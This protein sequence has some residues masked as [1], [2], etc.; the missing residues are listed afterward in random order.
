MYILYFHHKIG[1]L[2][3]QIAIAKSVNMPMTFISL[4]LG[5]K[6]LTIKKKPY[7]IE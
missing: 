1:Y 5:I 6:T 3:P 4:L 7:A 2:N